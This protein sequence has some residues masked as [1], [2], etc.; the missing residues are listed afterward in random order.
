MCP[1]LPGTFQLPASFPTLIINI[2]FNSQHHARQMTNYIITLLC[3]LGII[4]KP[5]E[6]K[7]QVLK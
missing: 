6:K 1:G 2:I 3:Y 4:Q 7:N 5:K